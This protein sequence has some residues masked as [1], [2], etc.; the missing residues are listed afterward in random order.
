VGRNDRELPI[1]GTIILRLARRL[2]RHRNGAVNYVINSVY[3]FRN[4]GADTWVRDGPAGSYI[5]IC[6]T[7]YIAGGTGNTTKRPLS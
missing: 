1:V 5:P 2:S 4:T 6:F 7:P 3:L